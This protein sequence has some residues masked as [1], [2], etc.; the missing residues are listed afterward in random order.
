MPEAPSWLK[1]SAAHF[2]RLSTIEKNAIAFMC[3]GNICRSAFASTYLSKILPPESD[4][5]VFSCGTMALVGHAMDTD[6]AEQ[7][8]FLGI[9]PEGH[10]AQ[11][12]TGRLLQRAA[13]II[14]FGPEH[15]AWLARHYPAFASRSFAIGQVARAVRQVATFPSIHELPALIR[16]D[17][18]TLKPVDWVPDPYRLG[19]E[20]ASAAVRRIA[21]EIDAIA[22]HINWSSHP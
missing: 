5:E 12:A 15:H 6:I 11:Q 21:H 22:A 20:A 1:L 17:F 9:D 8:R 16:A 10:V 19:P 7:A 4:C 14:V 2:E 13:C 3:T 18:P